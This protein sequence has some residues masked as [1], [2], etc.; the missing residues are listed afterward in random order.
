MKNPEVVDVTLDTVA[1]GS[2][3]RLPGLGRM[4][5]GERDGALVSINPTAHPHSHP[6]PHHLPH[7][8]IPLEP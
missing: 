6:R 4:F 8:R 3:P 1:E 7:L 5:V 2:A